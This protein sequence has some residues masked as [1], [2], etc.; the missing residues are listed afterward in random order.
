MKEKGEKKK[1]LLPG[2][3][4]GTAQQSSVLRTYYTPSWL[5]QE[6]T[7][8]ILALSAS[9]VQRMKTPK[10]NSTHRANCNSSGNTD[11]VFKCIWL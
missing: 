3:W 11:T 9:L 4:P 8:A 6:I 7:A 1:N 5:Q 2:M 10:Q